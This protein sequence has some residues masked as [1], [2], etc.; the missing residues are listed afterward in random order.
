MTRPNGKL[1]KSRKGMFSL[2]FD[3]DS[4]D[5]P[6]GGTCAVLVLR[7]DDYEQAKQ[8]ARA[9]F[10]DFDEYHAEIMTEGRLGWWRE[11]IRDHE[12][13]WTQDEERGCPGFLFETPCG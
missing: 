2:L 6:Y 11:S 13:Y 1:Y 5:S 3:E 12:R 4:W 9:Q 8:T 7:T 10:L